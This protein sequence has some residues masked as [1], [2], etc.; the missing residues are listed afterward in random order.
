VRLPD[1]ELRRIAA[2]CASF[3]VDGMRPTWWWPAPPSPMPPW[4]GA[5]AVDEHDVEVRPAG[6][7]AP[8]APGSL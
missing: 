3:D 2:L 7:A 1:L 6:P 8:Q 5:D 4:R